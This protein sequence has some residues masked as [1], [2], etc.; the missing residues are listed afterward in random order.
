MK[1]HKT[2]PMNLTNPGHARFL[3]AMLARTNLKAEDVENPTIEEWLV[4]PGDPAL[5]CVCCA[6]NSHASDEPWSKVTWK[7]RGAREG[8]VL[9]TGDEICNWNAMVTSYLQQ[10][11]S[12]SLS[13]LSEMGVPVGFHVVAAYFA[14]TGVVGPT[15][16][17]VSV[18]EKARKVLAYALTDGREITL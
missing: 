5:V 6:G 11:K 9:M 4:E 18:D 1:L 10:T 13:E 8:A 3:A 2:I 15:V 7:V 17:W 12:P 16:A 14:R